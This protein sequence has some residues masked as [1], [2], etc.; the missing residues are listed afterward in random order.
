MKKIVLVLLFALSLFVFIACD[1]KGI[2]IDDNG[3]AL[4]DES[5]KGLELVSSFEFADANGFDYSVSQIHK[6]DVVN[7]H[8]IKVRLQRDDKTIGCKEEKT[9]QL[10]S[11]IIEEQYTEKTVV[12]Y[13]D[14][15]KIGSLNDEVWEWQDGSLDDFVGLNLSKL[16]FDKKK[17]INLTLNTIGDIKVLA[18]GMTSGDAATFLGLSQ[19]ITDFTIEIKYN[20]DA[21]QLYSFKMSY[22]QALT[23]MVFNFMPVYSNSDIKLPS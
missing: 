6:K 7:Y 17:I 21:T 2:F 5:T 14:G 22:S 18:F 1:G 9:K 4:I 23:T 12:T 10:N 8:A 13:Y 15:E 16:K 11:E 20:A 19:E 3:Q